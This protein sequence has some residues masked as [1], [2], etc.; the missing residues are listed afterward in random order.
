MTKKKIES[1]TKKLH[2]SKRISDSEKTSVLQQLRVLG[3]TT[4]IYLM[5]GSDITA[6]AETLS[7]G[8]QNALVWNLIVFTGIGIVIKMIDSYLTV[9]ND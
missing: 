9:E 8:S 1:I 7:E 2:P 5:Y 3:I 6:Y 4:I